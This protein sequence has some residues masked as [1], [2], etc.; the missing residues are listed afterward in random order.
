MREIKVGDRFG[1]LV[2]IKKIS[3][4]RSSEGK[5]PAFESYKKDDF[6]KSV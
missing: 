5:S 2:V 3:K 4:G 6:P 1:R